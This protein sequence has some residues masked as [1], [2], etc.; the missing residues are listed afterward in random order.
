MPRMRSTVLVVFVVLGIA[1]CSSAAASDEPAPPARVVRVHGV[2]E[3]R[4]ILT[5]KAV[6]RLGLKTAP[7]AASIDRAQRSVLG[8]D[9]RPART[10]LGVRAGS[11]A[12]VPAGAGDGRP[13]RR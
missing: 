8:V 7:M 6:R 9:L 2:K 12:H 10:D 13:R 11:P 1:A 5:P 3:R 4:I